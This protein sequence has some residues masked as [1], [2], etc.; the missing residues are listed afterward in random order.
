MPIQDSVPVETLERTV[1]TDFENFQDMANRSVAELAASLVRTLEIPTGGTA[2]TTTVR[3][4]VASGLQID[5][6]GAAINVRPGFLIQN[7]AAAP[8][9]V[10]TPGAFDS[11][12]RF[13]LHLASAVQADPWDA[14]TAFWL[15]QARVVRTTTLSEVRDIFDAILQVFNPSA[16]PLNKRYESQVE[17]AWKKGTATN[18]PTPDAGY[19]PIGWVYRPAGFAAITEANCGSLSIQLEDLAPRSFDESGVNRASF[20]YNST[21]GIGR[22]STT[23]YCDLAA[24]VYGLK[25]RFK[26]SAAVP[27]EP[28]NSAY[29]PTADAAALA[30]AGTIGYVYIAPLPDAMPSKV[31]G[32][33]VGAKVRGMIVTSRTAP[34]SL[35]RNSGNIT[36]PAPFSNYSIGAGTAAHVGIVRV[37]SAPNSI[38][39]VATSRTGH[40]R[41]EAREFNNNNFP[42]TQ[43]NGYTGPAGPGYNLAV[44][45]PGGTEDVPYGVQ[46]ECF[47]EHT[48]LD[49]A[50]VAKAIETTFGMGAGGAADLIATPTLWPRMMLDTDT[51][52]SKE[53]ALYP[54]DSDLTMTVAFVPRTVTLA[55]SPGGAAD[56]G[57]TDERA[58]WHGFQF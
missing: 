33:P 36:P 31:H 30:F 8:P 47:L 13:G 54:Q 27:Y 22:S 14:S 46:L 28:L 21:N 16:A 45:G 56:G 34:D 25:C 53:F 37:D 43:A 39:F 11:S 26:A 4:H 57:N 58:G 15:L 52:Q 9:D 49:V 19:A 7:V 48:D 12:Y 3:T 24:D 51:L 10:P 35:G 42:L 44:L 17:F 5:A 6:A 55:V 29:V 23:A 20:R 18:I 1:E 50:A 32:A 2:P 40:G 38:E 41:M